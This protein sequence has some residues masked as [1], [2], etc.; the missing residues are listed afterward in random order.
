MSTPI[1][2]C[3]MDEK[4]LPIDGFERYE[5]S[6]LGCVRRADTLRPLKPS[7][8]RR[9]NGYLVA[10]RVNL[11]RGNMRYVHRLVLEAFVGPP[12]PGTEACHN[13]GDPSNNNLKNLRWDT[14]A[15]NMA[16]QH[17]H[18]TKSNPP[19]H[20]GE[21]HHKTTLREAQIREIRLTPERCGIYAD[22]AKSYGISQQTVRRIRRRETWKHLE[23]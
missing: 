13:D 4:W 16:D 10:M 17:W 19:V 15:A 14:H 7:P 5:V 9:P 2:S 1:V 11:G 21:R 23:L 22:L 18:G 6:S 20:I 8:K 12:P 3:G